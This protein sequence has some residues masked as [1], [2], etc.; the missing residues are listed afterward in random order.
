MRDSMIPAHDGFH[1]APQQYKQPNRLATWLAEQWCPADVIRREKQLGRNGVCL[2]P[3]NLPPNV[4]ILVPIS[5]TTLRGGLTIATH[6]NW[7]AAL[8]ILKKRTGAA[9]VYSNCEYPFPGA[10]DEEERQRRRVLALDYLDYTRVNFNPAS[11][12]KASRPMN[13]SV[14]ECLAIRD[15]IGRQGL[16]CDT[17]VIVTGVGHARSAKKIWQHNFPNSRIVVYAATDFNYEW[18]PDHYVNL[19]KGPWGWLYANFARHLLLCT[20]GVERTGNFRHNS[21]RE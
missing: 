13:N 9:I 17:I 4:D 7:C 20:I 12:I 14:E 21:S 8:D 2:L 1:E 16:K 11:I 18:Q 6:S 15:E 3:N 19:Q 10:A 5:Y